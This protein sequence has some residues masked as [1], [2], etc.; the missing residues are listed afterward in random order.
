MQ[1]ES[2][3]ATKIFTNDKAALVPNVH[4]ALPP[5]KLQHLP[6]NPTSYGVYLVAGNQSS[7][8]S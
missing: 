6:T 1:S 8:H 3:K 7:L 4:V 2:S 5:K